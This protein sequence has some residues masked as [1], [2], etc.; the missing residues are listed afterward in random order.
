MSF[1]LGHARDMCKQPLAVMA[2]AGDQAENVHY[3]PNGNSTF[4]RANVNFTAKAE[5]TRVAF[6][7]YRGGTEESRVEP[8]KEEEEKAEKLVATTKKKP[9]VWE[10]LEREFKK[11]KRSR[12][13]IVKV[14]WNSK[15][16]LEFT[17][18]REDQMKLKYPQLFSDVSS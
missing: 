1:S 9:T 11:L 8:I 7:S 13:A 18:E 6:Y 10:I 14:R 12:I 4:Q 3:T 5:K 2:F 16:G 17:W 15:R